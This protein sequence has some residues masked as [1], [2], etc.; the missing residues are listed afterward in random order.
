[1]LKP[2]I[3]LAKGKHTFL[4]ERF[5]GELHTHHG[6][7]KLDELKN[8]NF[9]DEIE[10]HLGVKYKILPYRAVDFFKHFKRTATPIMPKDI[11]AIIAYTGLSPDSLILDAGTGTG[12]LS[13]YLAYFNKYGEVITVEKRK[14]FALIA[15]RNFKLAGLKNIHQIIGDVREV[16]EGFKKEFDLIVLDMKDDVEFIPKA[17]EI[18][19]F[20]GHLVVYNPYIEATRAVYEK[21][22]EVG[23]RNVESFEIVRIDYEHKRV[24]TRPFTRVWHTGFLVI[25]RKI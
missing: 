7:I 9:G 23:F 8:K 24:G 3:I 19:K 22:L 16:A 2:P 25:G 18:L 10:T 1:M 6:I 14:E 13:A 11:G 20:G 17:K 5:E 4:V 15:R 21:M 12:M